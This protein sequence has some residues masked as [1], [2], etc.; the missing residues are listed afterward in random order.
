MSNPN[1][2]PNPGGRI[3]LP[4]EVLK[5]KKELRIEFDRQFCRIV[6][7]DLR[8]IK[9]LLADPNCSV[10]ERIIV[11][12]IAQATLHGITASFTTMM[13]RTLGHAM[14]TSETEARDSAEAAK[15]LMTIPKEEQIKLIEQRLKE[16]KDE[17]D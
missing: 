17:R 12:E 1:P 9:S 16:L 4:W 11:K 15:Q 13:N 7:M 2:V 6:S 14:D 10:I 5:A 3:K 8:E